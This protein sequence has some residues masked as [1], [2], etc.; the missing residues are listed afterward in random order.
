MA[1]RRSS[2]RFL[3]EATAAILLGNVFRW[4]QLKRHHALELI[5]VSFVNG[6]HATGTDR[7]EDPVVRDAFY[8]EGLHGASSGID[9]TEVSLARTKVVELSYLSTDPD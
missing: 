1:Q 2:A 4:E 9:Y 7:L 8:G 5:V 6:T 3:K